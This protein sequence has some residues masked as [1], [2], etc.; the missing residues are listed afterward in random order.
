MAK[1]PLAAPLEGQVIV[2]FGGNGLLGREFVSAIAQAG[3]T[4]ISADIQA[5]GNEHAMTVDTNSKASLLAL[6]DALH[7]KYGRIDAI[8]NSAYPRNANYGRK[9]FDIAHEDFCE[10]LSLNLGGMF[11]ASQQAAVY[12][13]KQGY[14]NIIHIASVYGVIAP[15][16]EIYDGTAMTMPAEYAA[17]KSAVIHLSKYIAK[18]LKGMQIR[19]NC[20]SPGGILDRQ[21]DAFLKAYG[22]QCLNRGMLDASDING[23]L[24]FLLS[25]AS[26]DINGQNIV[27]DD[28][29]TL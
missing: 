4:A 12:F 29:F 16:F 27:V 25:Q 20:I 13:K 17:I 3:G 22:D 1:T 18:S 15:K 6:I 5:A 2:V 9:F 28:G 10:N 7:A 26:K 24:I 14:G 11:L 8:V 19:V 23:T 21:A